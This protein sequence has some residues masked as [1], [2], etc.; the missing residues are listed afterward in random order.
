MKKGETNYVSDKIRSFEKLGIS[1]NENSRKI[2]VITVTNKKVSLFFF[3][4]GF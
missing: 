3:I 2:T 4:T 1:K